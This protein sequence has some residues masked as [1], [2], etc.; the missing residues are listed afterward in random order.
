MPSNTVKGLNLQ[1]QETQSKYKENHIQDYK[2]QN[3]ENYR[4]QKDLE[5]RQ[6]KNTNSKYIFL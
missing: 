2:R 6:R 1:M 4:L 5:G 3:T